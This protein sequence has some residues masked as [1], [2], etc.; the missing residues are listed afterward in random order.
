[1]PG[2]QFSLGALS[3]NTGTVD[4]NGVLWTAE[5]LE[6]W[7]SPDI[8]EDVIDR[9]FRHGQL[10]GTS[11]YSGRPMSLIG[12]LIGTGTVT[13]LRAAR[14]ALVK[15][16]DLT[17]SDATLTVLETPSKQCAVRRSGRLGLQQTGTH[18]L[19][20]NLG[21]LAV[22]P[23]KYA[24]STTTVSIGTGATVAGTVGGDASTPTV[25]TLTPG[26]SGMT[27][28]E[29]VSGQTMTVSTGAAVVVSSA[30]DT[31]KVSGSL[32]FARLTAG[33]FIDL[34]GGNSFSFT[35]SGGSASVV[36]TAAWI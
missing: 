25:I 2:L 23:R 6:G 16:T 14:A 26:G 24:T 9:A 18:L 30:D 22:D 19:R 29:T 35:T 36:Y 4:A 11:Y 28:T 3:F 32:A 13:D 33:S 1:M 15:A 8:R 21:L 34:Q 5:S 27:L 20:F 17:S 12:T 10:R 7:D 31:V